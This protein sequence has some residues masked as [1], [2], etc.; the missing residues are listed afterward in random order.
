MYTYITVIFSVFSFPCV[1]S[2]H[3]DSKNCVG[4][5]FNEFKVRHNFMKHF[6]KLVLQPC[7]VCFI[8]LSPGM[9]LTVTVFFPH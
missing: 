6:A 9:L 2:C 1:S 8:G 4:L 3:Q 7:D 5:G